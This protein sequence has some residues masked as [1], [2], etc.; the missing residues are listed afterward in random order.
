MAKDSGLIG[1][2]RALQNLVQRGEAATLE[3]AQQVLSSRG[4]AARLQ[5]MV[6]RGDAADLEEA[7]TAIGRKGR[8]A[9]AA[10]TLA[11]LGRGQQRSQRHLSPCAATG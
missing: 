6:D 3:E 11:R 10:S 7:A 2:G 4:Y 9:A 8:S 5:N 1:H